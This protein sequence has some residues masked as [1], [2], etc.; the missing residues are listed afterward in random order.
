MYEKKHSVNSINK[1]KI[2]LIGKT[3]SKE[4]KI[5]MSNS[6]KNKPPMTDET[7]EKL[8]QINLGKKYETKPILQI[9]TNGDIIKEWPGIVICANELK[10]NISG[11]SK[12]LTGLSKTTKGFKFKYKNKSI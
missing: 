2:K 10:L 4:S 6:A 5:K 8:R 9:D 12:V 1:I 3:R 7:K 11:I